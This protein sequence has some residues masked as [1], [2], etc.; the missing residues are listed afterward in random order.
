MAR[1]R[2]F[3]ESEVIEKAA[4][5][6]ASFGYNATSIDDLVVVTGLQR[7]SLYKA[8]GSKLNL[9]TLCFDNHVDSANWSKSTLGTD[10]LIVALRDV[11]AHDAVIRRKSKMAIS[12][13][14]K[15]K[16]ANLMGLRLIE[17]MEK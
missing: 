13:V 9:F 4:I 7:G 5:H 11:V 8:F 17:K 16:A 10:L 6:F 2:L 3:I 14:S 12:K 15:A 1:P